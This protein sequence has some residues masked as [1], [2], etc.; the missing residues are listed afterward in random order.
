MEN[1]PGRVII[2]VSEGLNME[3]DVQ[4]N[5]YD[6]QVSTELWPYIVSLFSSTNL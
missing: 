2:T 1:L 3:W 4:H 6:G 5:G